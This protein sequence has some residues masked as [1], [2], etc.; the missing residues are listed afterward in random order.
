MLWLAIKARFDENGTALSLGSIDLEHTGPLSCKIG[1]L[2]NAAAYQAIYL[3]VLFT[4]FDLKV[5]SN[6]LLAISK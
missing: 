6:L 1:K 2:E 3:S 5:V 4:I